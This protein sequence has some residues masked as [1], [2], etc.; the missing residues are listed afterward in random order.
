MQ[1]FFIVTVTSKINPICHGLLGPD[2][3]MGG[4]GFKLPGLNLTHDFN[5]FQILFLQGYV[6]GK[7]PKYEAPSF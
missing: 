1:N 3:F 2:R 4:G 7:K 5:D 6:K